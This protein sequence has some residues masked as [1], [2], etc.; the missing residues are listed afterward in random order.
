L[1]LVIVV[2]SNFVGVG[3]LLVAI[4]SDDLSVSERFSDELGHFLHSSFDQHFFDFFDDSAVWIENFVRF[5]G[6]DDADH[7]V[8]TDLPK[9]SLDGRENNDK[10]LSV[11]LIQRKNG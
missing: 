3:E 5:G 8:T 1:A 2:K 10:S 11:R 7:D 4:A 9:K 6:E